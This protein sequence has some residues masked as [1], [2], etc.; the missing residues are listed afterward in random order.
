MKVNKPI[1]Q[2]SFGIPPHL[3]KAHEEAVKNKQEAE[4]RQ[5]RKDEFMK[6][7][8]ESSGPEVLEDNFGEAPVEHVPKAESSEEIVE[9]ATKAKTPLTNLEEMGINLDDEDFQKLIFKGYIEKDV[10]VIPS[11][12]GSKPLIATFKLLTGNEY[13]LIDELVGEEIKVLD[14]TNDGFQTRRS[15]WILALGLTKL[16]GK[17]ICPPVLGKDKKIN[18]KATYKRKREIVGLLSPAVLT[19]MMKIHG[20]FTL[21]ANAIIADPDANYLKKS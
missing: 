21:A 9:D 2:G 15:M 6:Q 11:I 14:M 18:F 16:M 5:E 20:T 10:E 17:P 3:K 4:E 12:R 19:K 8:E 13:D 7:V 1:S